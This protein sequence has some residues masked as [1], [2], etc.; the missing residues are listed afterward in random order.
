MTSA[1]QLDGSTWRKASRSDNKGGECVEVAM[2]S[3]VV[4]VRDSKNPA[5]GLLAVTPDSWRAFTDSL[6]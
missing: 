6:R 1:P 5:G 4:A 2:T 3:Q